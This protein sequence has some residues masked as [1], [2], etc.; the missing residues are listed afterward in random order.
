MFESASR[1]AFEDISSKSKF[2][3]RGLIYLAGQPSRLFSQPA[4]LVFP[5]HIDHRK[6]VNGDN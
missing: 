5:G 2:C 3:P 4:Q 1:G 6:Q